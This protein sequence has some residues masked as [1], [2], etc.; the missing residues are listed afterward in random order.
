M[1]RIGRAVGLVLGATLALGCAVPETRGLGASGVVASATPD[2]TAAGVL[3][4]ERGGNAIDAAVAVAFSLGVTEP[5]GSGLC[6]QAFLL[7]Q[8]PGQPAF[9]ING[10]TLSPAATPASASR[11]ELRGRRASTVPSMVKVLAFAHARF[12]SG[13]LFW[14]DLLAPAIHSAETGFELGRFRRAII[15]RYA[16]LLRRDPEV[17]RTFLRGDGT[18]P[19]VGDR[20]VQPALAATLRR[21]ADAGGEDFYRGEIAAAIA[22]DM[23]AHGGWI[24]RDD[25]RAFPEP[26]VSAALRGTYRGWDVFTLPPPAG[27]WVVLRA[28]RL[29]EQVP[30]ETLAGGRDAIVWMAEALLAAHRD[31]V[32]RPVTDLLRYGRQ[33]QER[34]DRPFVMS[35]ED[36]GETTHFCV[37]D[38]SGM[39]VSA[40]LSLN[41]YFGA[42]VMSKRLGM[43]YNNYMREFVVGDPEHA[44]ALAPRAMPY[45]SMSATIL[46]KDD[47]P[48][49]AVGSPGSRR[50][51]SAVVQVI[52]HWVDGGRSITDAVAEPRIHVVPETDTL[53]FE[54]R[55]EDPGLIGELEQR[56]F[57]LVVPLSS[58][59][60]TGGNP[61]FGGVH[62]L[63]RTGSGP[64]RAAADPRRDGAV[65][66][67]R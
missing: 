41:S 7:V 9:V 44:F 54:S 13:K 25:L 60:G 32:E 43:L 2:A 56:G 12:G 45:S 14:P 21:L 55:P 15:A 17:A 16:P 63:A 37:A 6:G 64:W 49:L 24:T 58:L 35:R 51:I 36:G 42:K 5:A 26:R 29:L 27:G 31:R 19:D 39:V 48:Q 53:M 23:A 67:V 61:Y 11:D 20:I 66:R 1:S 33:V 10:S 3:V 8:R 50:I 18:I 30:S 57:K 47:I 34:I 38:G 4:L 59:A 22:A 40:T 28:L 65:M 46:S 62:A 52:C